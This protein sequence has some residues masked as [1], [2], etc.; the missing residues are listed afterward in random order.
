MLE[1]ALELPDNED[2]GEEKS[3]EVRLRDQALEFIHEMGWLLHRNQVRFRLGGQDPNLCLF[4]FNRFR[5]LLEF[6]M[7]HDWCAVVKKLLCILFEGSIEPGEN[8]SP[9]LALREMGL[10][11]KAVR[12]NCKPM[13]ELLLRFSPNKSLDKQA[14]EQEEHVDSGQSSLFRPDAAGPAGLTP[15]HLAAC[16]DGL[17]DVLDALTDDPGSVCYFPKTQYADIHKVSVA[18]TH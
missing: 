15:L 11:H 10:L 17:E 7:D 18:L 16:T 13:V 9:E 3:R 5:W 1:D 8:A 4:S 2:D 14:L 6:S 12:R